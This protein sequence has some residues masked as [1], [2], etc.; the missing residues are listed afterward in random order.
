[1][2][3]LS[4][5]FCPSLSF[6]HCLCLSF[7][8]CLF[9]YLSLSLLCSFLVIF[10]LFLPAALLLIPCTELPFVFIHDPSVP[11]FLLQLKSDIHSLRFFCSILLFV[12]CVAQTGKIDMSPFIPIFG[13]Q[14]VIAQWL[15]QLLASGE[16]PGSIPAREIIY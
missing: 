9:I 6:S 14:V 5:F 12:T 2:P 10:Y 1:M 7:S 4:L 13:N 3:S 8:Q 15:A 16:V 11:G